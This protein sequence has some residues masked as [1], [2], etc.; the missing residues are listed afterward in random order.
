MSFPT[1]PVS[2]LGAK[3]EGTLQQYFLLLSQFAF[4]K[5]KDLIEKERE[6]HKASFGSSWALMVHTLTQFALAEKS[7]MGL[8]FLEQKWFGRSKDSLR[9][10]YQLVMGEL[11]RV[12]EGV[13]QQELL[14]CGLPGPT[15]EFEK[16]IGHLCS[17]LCEFVRARQ[18]TMDFYE[19]ISLLG[20]NKNLSYEDLLAVITD[21]IQA[22][23]KSFHH[24]IIGS[25]K[26]GFTYE[27]DV[28]NHLVNSQILMSE[29]QFLPSLLQ[30]HQAHSKLVSWGASA[31]AKETTKR[32]M[33]GTT[34]KT[35]FYWPALYYWLMKYKSL[36]V[37]KFSLY[38]YDILSKQTTAVDMRSLSA[39]NTEDY[40]ARITAFQKKTDALN[41]SLVLDISGIEDT[42]KGPGYHHP[43]KQVETPTGVDSFPAVFSYPGEHPT[44]HWPNV[45]MMISNQTTD[46]SSTDKVNCFYDKAVQ[47]TYFIT[48]ADPR[49]AIV[50]IYETKKSEKDSYVNNF[51]LELNSQ[52]RCVKLF[53]NL[54]PG[55][56]VRGST[57]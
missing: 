32:S 45:V 7:Y 55:S 48:H 41:V 11:R 36:L 46:G 12:E 56:R 37:A 10:S 57:K 44:H 35:V 39:K 49:I 13:Q 53:S 9:N 6:A 47:S 18:K 52:L 5:A 25:L 4:D 15:V 19:Q 34:S 17:Q 14:G 28:I 50:V 26:S 29:W 1:S 8:G 42:Y 23:S 24:P 40:V 38:F 43:D 33:F 20:T 21:I 30:L 31:Q 54:K 3:E 51:L 16:L 22:H 2:P 27:C